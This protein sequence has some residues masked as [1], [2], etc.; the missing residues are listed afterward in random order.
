MNSIDPLYEFWSVYDCIRGEAQVRLKNSSTAVD[1]ES[2]FDG[3]DTL[4]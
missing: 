2:E 4:Y 3:A 1:V